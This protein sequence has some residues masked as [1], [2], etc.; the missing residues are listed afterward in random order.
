VEIYSLSKTEQEIL[1]LLW[2]R[3]Q[4]MSGA[5]FWEY[6]NSHGKECKRSTVNTYLTRMTDKGFLVKNG[7]KY[8]YAYT[9]EEFDAKHAEEV[10]NQ[11]FE[12]SLL[13]FVAAF[14][15]T[16]KISKKEA[17]ELREYLEGLHE[18]E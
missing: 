3:G 10:L 17:A 9:K 1:N 2:K 5:D 18:K 16:N 8:M 12:G 11:R 13:R 7:K 15:G 14:G 6:F 4:W